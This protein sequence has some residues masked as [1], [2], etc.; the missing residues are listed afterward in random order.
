MCVP[1]IVFGREASL[2]TATVA[3]EMD[4]LRLKIDKGLR[5]VAG[6]YRPLGIDQ[7]IVSFT[8]LLDCLL[9]LAYLLVHPVLRRAHR[10]GSKK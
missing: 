5:N 8:A 6:T 3:G 10:I 2:I 1:D 9:N 7:D 4:E